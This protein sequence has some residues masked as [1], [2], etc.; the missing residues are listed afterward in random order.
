MS[1]KIIVLDLDGTLTNSK[2]EIMPKTKQALMR[3]QKEGK[4]VV[5]ASG[6]PTPGILQLA[7]ELQL[8]QYGG[9]ILSFNGAKI[10]NCK[11]KKI[12]YNKT[13]PQEYTSRI[14]DYAKSVGIGVLSYT[15]DKIILGNGVDQYSKLEAKINQ[16]PM[17]ECSDFVSFFDAPVNKF[18]MT[19]EPEKIL[20]AQGALREMFGEELNIFRSEPFFLE[21]M[22]PKVDKAYSL[23]KLLESLGEDKSEMICCGDGFNDLSM[24]EFAGLGV[25]M[26]NA[27]EEVKK[28]A[29]FITCSNDEDGV[30]QVIE[31]FM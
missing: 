6:R 23:R 1:Y 30:A 20:T 8:E 7:E 29:D 14:Y 24:I 21:I 25:A 17:E 2:K 18:L 5:L 10:I 27:Q 9:Y 12:V 11:T 16:L 15:E 13:V 31:T 22:P 3:I 19:G 28:A 26:E 4:A